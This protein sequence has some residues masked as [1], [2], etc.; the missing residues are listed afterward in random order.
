M[1]AARKT[2]LVVFGVWLA[3]WAIRA[4]GPSDFLDND[5]ERPAAYTMDVVVHDRWACQVDTDGDIT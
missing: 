3:M 2:A 1:I 4:L 5:Q